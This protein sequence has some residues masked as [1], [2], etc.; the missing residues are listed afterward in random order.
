MAQLDEVKMAV[1]MLVAGGERFTV[2]DVTGM[3]GKPYPTTSAYLSHYYQKWG[4][5]REKKPGDIV[6]HYYGNGPKPKPIKEVVQPTVPLVQPTPTMM[7]FLDGLEWLVNDY[8]RLKDD[9]G[10]LYGRFSGIM[11]EVTNLR[12]ANMK[13]RDETP[14]EIPERRN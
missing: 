9:W 8:R 3:V 14:A 10:N 1:D 12:G 6:Y 2:S 7:D 11:R 4:L 13:V 5:A